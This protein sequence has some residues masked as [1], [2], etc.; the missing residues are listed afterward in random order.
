MTESDAKQKVLERL[1]AESLVV[2]PHCLDLILEK[3][4]DVGEL[5]REAGKTGVWLVTE[6]FLRGFIKTDAELTKAA[7]ELAGVE[8]KKQETVEV[9]RSRKIFAKE[10]ESKLVIDDESDVTGK[11]TCDGTLENFVEYFNNRYSSIR[12][13]LRER[14]ECRT[15]VTI[16]AAKKL[17]G[18]KVAVICMI[19]EKRESKKGHRFLEVEDPTGTLTALITE[20]KQELGRL[21]A[22]LMLDEVV[23]IQGT[24]RNSLFLVNDITQ[25]DVPY[26][27]KPHTADE[28]VYAAFL[29]DI[30]VGSYLFL[31]KEFY[32][33]VE[34]LKGGGADREIAERVK[35]VLIAGDLADG[36][37]IYPNQ[38]KELTIPDI[39]RQY[40]FLARLLED[41]PDYIEVVA[42]MGNHDAVRGAEPQ[43]RLSRDI[44][45]RLFDLPNVHVTGNPVR[46]SMHGVRTLM[47][48]GTSLDTIIGNLSDCSYSAPEKAMIQYLIRRNLVPSYGA[49]MI[50]PE[51]K[52]YL[53]IKEVPDILHCGH[54]H[55]NGYATYR[56]VKII[57][58]GT[59]QAKTRYQEQL[60]HQPTPCRVPVINLKNHEVSVHHFQ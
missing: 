26:N 40:D 54:V 31:E 17:Q 60:G 51:N 39:Y 20:D 3:N 9:V 58:S 4:I 49:D 35:Y 27:T 12:D 14:P 53:T 41:I 59:W 13:I 16:E 7:E 10:V 29:S 33:F 43:P 57:N 48:H 15:A 21:Y 11:S 25:P 5:S 36:V 6:D 19:T 28:E 55:T 42:C 1:S 45:G 46:L 30:H 56:G 44:G 23:C 52:D 50:A 24:L 18:E 37:G 47:Y 22:R 32:S 34:W 8:P 2:S 38:D